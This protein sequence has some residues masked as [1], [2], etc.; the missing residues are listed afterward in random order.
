MKKII[1]FFKRINNINGDINTY[2]PGVNNII[3]DGSITSNG[4]NINE[5]N[6]NRSETQMPAEGLTHAA[7]TEKLVRYRADMKNLHNI[8][9]PTKTDDNENK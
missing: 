8:I 7:I 5:P 9:N 6:V 1:N 3:Y 2:N 4:N